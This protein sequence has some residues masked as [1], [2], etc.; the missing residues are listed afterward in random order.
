MARVYVAM[1]RAHSIQSN[2]CEETRTS[3]QD[4][5]LAENL[6]ANRGI[7]HPWC[8]GEAADPSPSPGLNA[9]IPGTTSSRPNL[10]N[11]HTNHR[12]NNDDNNNTMWIFSNKVPRL[13]GLRI[14][15][16]KYN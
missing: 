16:C 3:G 15:S 8:R 9:M 12:N 11:S 5:L 6:I 10:N 4:A 1:G 14:T 13:L 7:T 2:G